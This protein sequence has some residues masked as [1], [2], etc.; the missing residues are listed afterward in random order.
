VQGQADVVDRLDARDLAIE[1]DPR[2][3]REVLDQVVDLEER[4]ALGHD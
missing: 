3:D 1:H 2:L 4:I